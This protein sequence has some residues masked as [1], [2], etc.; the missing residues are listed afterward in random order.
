MFTILLHS[1]KTMVPTLSMSKLSVPYFQHEAKTLRRSIAGLNVA[2]IVECMHV[3]SSLAQTVQAMYRSPLLTPSATIDIFRGDI[4][5]GLRAL[6]FTQTQK[7]FAQKH[8]VILSGLYGI[9]KPYDGIT[10]YRLEA[11]YR[12]PAEPY[13]NMYVFWG[14]RIAKRL[15]SSGPIINVTSVEYEKF[16][17]PYVDTR[18]VITPRF[19]SIVKPGSAPKFV[20]VHAKI[21]RG[22]FARWLILRGKDDVNGLEAFDD[23]GYEYDPVRSTSRQPV[24]VCRHFEGVGLSQRLVG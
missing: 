14:D 11:A 9:L 15:P 2:Q 3:S 12:L 19:L 17:V 24:Y 10:P 5:S 22:A 18:R 21:A 4:Y 1:S 20:A 7:Q 16:V 6:D 13:K 23:L 8:L